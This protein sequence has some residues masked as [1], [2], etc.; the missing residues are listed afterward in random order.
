MSRLNTM[1]KNS[2]FT[3][4]MICAE[5]RAKYYAALQKVKR[6][7]LVRVKR[8]VF[9]KPIDLADVMID[10]EKI[11]PGGILCMYSAWSYYGLTTQIPQ[12]YDV[13]I[14]R[15]WKV[16]LPQYPAFSVHSLTDKVLNTGVTN[17]KISGYDVKIYDLEKSVCDAVKFRNRIGLDVCTEIVRNYLRR[18]DRSLAKLLNYAKI[19]R[20][21]KIVEMYIVMGV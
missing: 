15:G 4:N 10:I 16:T 18:K 13:A 11:I 19:L 6:G 7:N 1:K 5:G 21:S 9:A 14:K 3:S 8:G 2:F 20:V 17:A 12:Q